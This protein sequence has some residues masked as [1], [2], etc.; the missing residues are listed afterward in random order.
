MPLLVTA[1]T[2]SKI[3]L[4]ALSD[5]SCTIYASSTI[6]HADL[7]RS[8]PPTKTHPSKQ[9]NPPLDQTEITSLTT[10]TSQI[11]HLHQ[12][13]NLVRPLTEIPRLLSPSPRLHGIR[14]LSLFRAIHALNK[15]G[16]LV[17]PLRHSWRPDSR[18]VSLRELL[19][20]QC[21]PPVT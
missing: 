18:S 13:D 12:Q 8:V 10:H 16:S 20:H 17:I 2:L 3:S 1:H 7:P 11:L 21:S 6:S 9:R 15:N 5:T 19:Y 14:S 4:T